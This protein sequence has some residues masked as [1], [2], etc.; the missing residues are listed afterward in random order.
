MIFIPGGLD[1]LT[2]GGENEGEKTETGEDPEVCSR[3]GLAR[4]DSPHLAY[5]LASLTGERLREME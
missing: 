2:G 1:S 4:D 5:S 3:D